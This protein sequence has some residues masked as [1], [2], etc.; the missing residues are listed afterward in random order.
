MRLTSECYAILFSFWLVAEHRAPH[1]LGRKFWTI[2]QLR[3]ENFAFPHR[4]LA[5]ACWLCLWTNTK[6]QR[7]PQRHSRSREGGPLSSNRR[8]K[9]KFLVLTNRRRERTGTLCVG[10]SSGKYNCRV[11]RVIL[12]HT[13]VEGK[14]SDCLPRTHSRLTLRTDYENDNLPYIF[15]FYD[16][17]N[18][19]LPST[20]TGVHFQL[21]LVILIDL[22]Q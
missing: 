1:V 14:L 4:R 12:I 7:K 3:C 13:Y 17:E 20:K 21:D 9:I 18:D 2:W 15:N 16:Y 10:N 5:A 8:V 19:N 11:L 6:R 22:L